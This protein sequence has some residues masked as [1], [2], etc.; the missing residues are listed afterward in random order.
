M[1]SLFHRYHPFFSEVKGPLCTNPHFQHWIF[2]VL[3]SGLTD[4]NETHRV[5]DSDAMHRA[6]YV[7]AMVFA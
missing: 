6:I 1:V 5:F 4:N 3:I 7:K 2:P